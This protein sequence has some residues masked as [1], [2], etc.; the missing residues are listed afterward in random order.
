MQD[1]YNNVFQQKVMGRLSKQKEMKAILDKITTTTD[2]TSSQIDSIVQYHSREELIRNLRERKE[3]FHLPEAHK[4]YCQTLA[5]QAQDCSGWLIELPEYREWLSTVPARGDTESKNSSPAILCIEGDRGFGK[6]ME[7]FCAKNDIEDIED[8]GA[9][10]TALLYF[11]FKTGNEELQDSSKALEALLHQLLD[12]IPTL[13][14]T[15]DEK[16]IAA[17][18][19]IIDSHRQVV[20]GEYRSEN[21]PGIPTVSENA[22]LVD[23]KSMQGLNFFTKLI[24]LIVEAC[25]LQ[26]F[27]ILDAVDECKD[28]IQKDLVALLE[29]M[30]CDQKGTIRILISTRSRIA[31][32]PTITASDTKTKIRGV[33]HSPLMEDSYVETEYIYITKEK[34]RR[35]LNKF[36]RERIAPLIDKRVSGSAWGPHEDQDGRLSEIATIISEK[37]KGDF[38]YAKMVIGNLE[39]PSRLSLK[40]RLKNLPTVAKMGDFYHRAL[41]ALT[42][43]QRNL[44]AFA[45]RWVVWGVSTI[46]TV[47]I[48][49]HYKEM[50][51]EE[52]DESDE[53]LEQMGN[54]VDPRDPDIVETIIHLRTAGRDFFTFG[55]E[56]SIDTPRSVQEWVK[57]ESKLRSGNSSVENLDIPIPEVNMVKSN[58]GKI[59]FE[60][61]FPGR[62]PFTLAATQPL[63]VRYLVEKGADV[64]QTSKE[65]ARPPLLIVLYL[66]AFGDDENQQY[67]ET[68]H[69]LVS[70][71]ANLNDKETIPPFQGASPLLYAAKS[72]DLRLIKAILDTGTVDIDHRDIGGAAVFHYLFSRPV[73]ASASESI[74]L[75]I[76]NVLLEAGAAINAQDN[77]SR[78]PLSWA[79]EFGDEQGV[80]ALLNTKL[81]NVS[82]EREASTFQVNIHDIDEVGQTCLHDLARR[83]INQKSD[84]AILK[85]LKAAG[86]NFSIKT[87]TGETPVL[88]A[89]RIHSPQLVKD[90][91]TYSC[92]QGDGAK[93]LQEVDIY[94]RNILH[95]IAD[96]LE[97]GWASVAE[98]LQRSLEK[99]GEK[100]AFLS[101]ST[102]GDVVSGYTPL[103]IAA[104]AGN[105]P[106][107]KFLTQASKPKGEE[108]KPTSIS[109]ALRICIRKLE[110][111]NNADRDDA[112]RSKDYKT[113]KRIQR[114]LL[115]I[116]DAYGAQVSDILPLR[117]VALRLGWDRLVNKLMT[118]D[119]LKLDLSDEYG[120]NAYHIA[121]LAGT[122]PQL[123]SFTI[124]THMDKRHVPPAK[125]SELDAKRKGEHVKLT[126]NNRGCS[127]D[128]KNLPWLYYN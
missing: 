65:E 10:N 22:S 23:G 7:L 100:E 46:T 99:C 3:R 81:F 97:V 61:N 110:R 115:T 96:R 38:S 42:K 121:S 63:T 88:K 43:E 66:A 108:N 18:I 94:G 117:E 26:V 67:L 103:H 95:N 15:K 5:S 106:M 69:Y 9:R 64:N 125:P 20:V 44:I 113:S 34:N 126:N 11:F 53:W 59:T 104:R 4:G 6:T 107:V 49:Q 50:F 68:A 76:L 111:M 31:I 102:Q 85:I 98:E 120:W 90:F 62:T 73:A 71:G 114:C 86:A 79:I 13:Q 122:I 51:L 36:V 47:E 75:E 45:L 89:S 35:S 80:E 32:D 21:K 116:L 29:S 17:V 33:K 28:C 56:G 123:S 119:L 48:A 127:H 84:A 30:V 37:V 55:K 57:E 12:L 93:I 70:K 41:E 60:L 92:N 58:G 87:K 2:K 52:A 54:G 109:T 112:S 39:Q 74:I 128:C 25:S 77:A 40:K 101:L 24:C 27:I 91:I 124:R 82:D 19:E 105:V 14:M 1:L 16:S 72:R 83:A 118:L 8:L 78:A